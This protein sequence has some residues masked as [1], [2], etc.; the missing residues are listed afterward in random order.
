MLNRSWFLFYGSKFNMNSK[1]TLAC[2]YGQM[3]DLI[4]CDAIDRGLAL[5]K[6][7]PKIYSFEEA[8]ALR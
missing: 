3:V 8:M 5:P 4:N 7:K 2:R 1:E 6:K